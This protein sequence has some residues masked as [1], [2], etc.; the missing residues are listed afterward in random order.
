MRYVASHPEVLDSDTDAV[1]RRSS[2]RGRVSWDSALRADKDD[3]Y[4]ALRRRD[5]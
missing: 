3:Q 2:Y 1:E 4:Y 5:T